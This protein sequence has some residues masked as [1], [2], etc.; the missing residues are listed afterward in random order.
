MGEE[1]RD[2]RLGKGR[3]EEVRRIKES[4]VIAV[5]A[6]TYPLLGA[7]E[8]VV[9]EGVDGVNWVIRVE[10]PLLHFVSSSELA[11]PADVRVVVTFSAVSEVGRCCK[12]RNTLG[13]ALD[14]L[15]SR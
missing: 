12:N 3:I 2:V 13:R 10:Q 9:S 6:F 14:G 8:K 5:R 1:V 11:I 15:S 7:E 4:T